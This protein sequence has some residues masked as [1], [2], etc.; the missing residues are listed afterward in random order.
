MKHLFI[1]NPAAGS[2]DRTAEYS[3]E[4]H[5]LCR[6]RELG[7]DIRVSTAPGEC[8]RFAREAAE[9]GEEYRLYACGGDGTLNEVAQG[10]AGYANVAVTVFSGGSGND[11]VKLF[12]DPQAFFSL[13][14]L[15][16]AQEATFDLIRCNDDIAM[17]ICS[18]G[19]DARIGTDVSRYK[20]LPLLQGFRAYAAST[21]VNV[22]KGIAEHYVV[23]LNGKRIEGEQTMI[24]VC[25]G[26]YYGG[27][28]NPVPEADPADGL[29]DV[30]LVKK[31]SRVQ[32]AG[33]IGKYK[34]GR[35]KELPKLVRHFRTEQVKIICDKPTP[36]NLDGELRTATEVTM[37]VA[38]EKLRFFYPRGLVWQQKT[39]VRLG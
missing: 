25:N 8:R 21:V 7:Y 3:Q 31:V 32:V 30:L 38:D 5:R 17:N 14:R 28:F 26:R 12:D 4:I 13:E 37:S 2:K 23:E 39:P 20:R 6:Q 11:F 27:G 10:A 34:A 35:Y 29:L 1:I 16:D 24:C 18:V 19:L 33:V 36:V 22:V 9:S 15:L